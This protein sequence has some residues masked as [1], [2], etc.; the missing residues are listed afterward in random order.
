MEAQRN[1]PEWDLAGLGMSKGWLRSEITVDPPEMMKFGPSS[2]EMEGVRVTI[3]VYNDAPEDFEAGDIVF[4][5]LGV[6]LISSDPQ[7]S[8]GR[9]RRARI[10][11]SEK[12]GRGVHYHQ[13]YELGTLFR[14]HDR[15]TLSNLGKPQ[16][17]DALFPGESMQYEL[18]ISSSE[19]PQISIQMEGSISRLHLFRV[20][21]Q[22]KSHN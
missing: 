22:L 4:V 3:T 21:N 1:D 5:G 18:E 12:F 14:Q 9:P 8:G 20:V 19:W 16:T 2:R 7:R 10:S 6:R 17:N 13:K 15:P 11:R